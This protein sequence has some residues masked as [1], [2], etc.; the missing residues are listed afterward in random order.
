MIETIPTIPTDD[1]EYYSDDGNILPTLAQAMNQ[2]FGHLLSARYD[3]DS[4]ELVIRAG[5][6]VAQFGKDGQLLGGQS[7]QQSS[8]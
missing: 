7:T 2:A 4:E 5:Q 3:S 8:P 1:L 6:A